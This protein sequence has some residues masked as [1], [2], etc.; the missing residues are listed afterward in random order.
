[1]GMLAL[2]SGIAW[3]FLALLTNGYV[4]PQAPLYLV[5]LAG[6]TAG[7]VTYGTSYAP[8]SINFMVLPL[9]VAAGCLVAKG[10]L[11]NYVLAFT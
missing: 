11:E 10:D 8:A 7:S 5:V 1:Y 4:T 6:L 3:A 9:L 2:A